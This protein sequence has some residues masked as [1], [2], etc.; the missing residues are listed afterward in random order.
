ML[1]MFTDM[2]LIP[3]R[4]FGMPGGIQKHT[5]VFTVIAAGLLAAFFDLSRIASL[6]AIFYLVMDMIIHWGV[7]RHLKD[8]VGAKSW[9]LLSAIILDLIVLGAFLTMKAASDPMIIAIS[10]AGTAG[11]FCVREIL[12]VASAKW[13]AL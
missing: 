5:L 8:D 1:A 9:I 12:S 2:N 10:F 6:G 7:Y 4:H 3:H 11:F 13:R